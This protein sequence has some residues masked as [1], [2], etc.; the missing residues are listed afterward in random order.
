V[1]FCL[2][3]GSIL[4]DYTSMLFDAKRPTGIPAEMWE[5]MGPNSPYKTTICGIAKTSDQKWFNAACKKGWWAMFDLEQDK[6]VSRQHCTLGQYGYISCPISVAVSPD[7]N[8]FYIVTRGGIVESYDIQ[9]LET[10][11]VKSIP[12]QSF[13]KIAVDPNNKFVFISS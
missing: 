10:R 1:K 13:V 4:K 2:T 5:V 3:D 9:A 11:E 7:D 8:F 6:C 12:N